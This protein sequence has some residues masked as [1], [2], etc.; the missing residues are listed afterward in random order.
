M[1]NTPELLKDV[2]QQ[3]ANGQQVLIQTVLKLQQQVADYENEIECHDQE[4]SDWEDECERLQAQNAAMR[5][6]LENAEQVFSNLHQAEPESPNNWKWH[7][8]FTQKALKDGAV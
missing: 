7:L 2:E 4:S 3:E 1:T 8:D 6:A 5:E